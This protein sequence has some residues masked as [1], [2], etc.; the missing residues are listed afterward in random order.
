ME[1]KKV[2]QPKNEVE[3]EPTLSLPAKVI[4]AVIIAL[5]MILFVLIW[6]GLG[7]GPIIAPRSVL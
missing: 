3:Q 4:L 6:K 2:G 7:G 1:D 5:L